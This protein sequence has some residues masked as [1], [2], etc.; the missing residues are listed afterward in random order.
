M[1][2]GRRYKPALTLT[3]S[4]TVFPLYDLD[5]S[6]PTLAEDPATLLDTLQTVSF[7][8]KPQSL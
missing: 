5:F 7:G 8:R 1:R 6:K 3:W 2:I 4:S